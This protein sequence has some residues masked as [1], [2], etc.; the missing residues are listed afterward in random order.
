M[1]RQPFGEFALFIGELPDDGP[2]RAVRGLGATAAEQPAASAR[3]A[4]TLSMDL[5]AK[6]HAWV[7]LKLDALAPPVQEERA[8]DMPFPPHGEMRRFPAWWPPRGRRADGAASS[9][10][11]W[12]GDITP[13]RR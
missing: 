8:F 4:K 7:R 11:L 13:A 3:F 2:A 6:G 5:R 1:V 10:G 9:S 12:S